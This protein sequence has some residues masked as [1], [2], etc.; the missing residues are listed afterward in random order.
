[1]SGDC[2]DSARTSETGTKA[3]RDIECTD[4]SGGAADGGRA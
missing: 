1:V 4:F 3:P 2:R